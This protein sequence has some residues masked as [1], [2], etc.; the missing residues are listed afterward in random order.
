MIEHAVD[1]PGIEIVCG[2]GIFEMFGRTDLEKIQARGRL[3]IPVL[4][5]KREILF[6]SPGGDVSKEADRVSGKVMKAFGRNAIFRDQVRGV[7]SQRFGTQCGI[8]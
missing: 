8:G 5:N 3:G 2:P 6:P 7:A 1:R 4:S